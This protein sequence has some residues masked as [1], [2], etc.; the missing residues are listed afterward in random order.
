MAR[1]KKHRV[2]TE[3][4]GNVDWHESLL[5]KLHPRR[6]SDMSPM[7]SA[8]LGAIVGKE[9]TVPALYGLSVTSDGFVV[10][11]HRFLGDVDVE[12]LKRNIVNLLHAA[13][14]FPEEVKLFLRLYAQNVTDWSG[15]ASIED[16]VADLLGSVSS[17]KYTGRDWEKTLAHLRE[18]RTD[19]GAKKS[20]EDVAKRRIAE[21]ERKLRR[22]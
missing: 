22:R 18:I 17:G 14:L 11:G 8:I 9:W 5:A 10:S 6:F 20:E 21:I 1:K 7:M 12:G 19:R 15:E 3:G 2:T 4:L 13:D 16:D